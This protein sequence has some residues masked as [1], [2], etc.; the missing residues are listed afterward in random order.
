[1]LRIGGTPGG[2]GC[3]TAS[4]AITIAAANPAAPRLIAVIIACPS[5]VLKTRSHRIRSIPPFGPM[6]RLAAALTDTVI[7]DSPAPLIHPVATSRIAHNLSL[8]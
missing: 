6:Q 3:P 7:P 2:S 8:G 4:P 1:M 5:G